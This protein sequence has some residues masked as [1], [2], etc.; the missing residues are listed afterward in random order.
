MKKV[1]AAL[2]VLAIVVLVQAVLPK[3][4]RADG[5]WRDVC[6]GGAKSGLTTALATAP[7]L[8]VSRSRD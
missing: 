3:Q 4:A 8:A 7:S 6:C 5:S 2:G 1:L